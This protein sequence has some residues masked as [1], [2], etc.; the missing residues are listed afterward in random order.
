MSAVDVTG[1]ESVSTLPTPAVPPPGKGITKSQGASSEQ[2]GRLHCTPVLIN[3]TL[4]CC[5]HWCGF[6]G[7]MPV[8]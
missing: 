8:A 6:V 1:M 2:M 4:Y 3:L 5:T 7:Q